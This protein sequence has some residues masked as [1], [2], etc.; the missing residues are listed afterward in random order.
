MLL[1]GLAGQAPA[2]LVH[3]DD[4]EL[5][6]HVGGQWQQDCGLRPRD[7]AQLLPL[8]GL[9]PVSF[10]LHDELWSEARGKSEPGVTS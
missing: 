3:S 8:A 4:P 7:S 10:K 6:G 9:L 1:R 2:H 5:V